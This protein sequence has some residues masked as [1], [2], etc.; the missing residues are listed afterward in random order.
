LTCKGAS[1]PFLFENKHHGDK[2]TNRT[3]TAEI[4][5]SFGLQQ[6]LQL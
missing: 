5:V 4:Y 6:Q 2:K 3:I 1:L